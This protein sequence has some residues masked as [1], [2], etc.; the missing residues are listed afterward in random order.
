MKILQEIKTLYKN[1]SLCLFIGAGVSR[2]CGLP[3]WPTLSNAVVEAAWPN[4]YQSYDYE[5]IALRASLN[6]LSPLEAMRYARQQL[7]NNFNQ[8]V[9]NALYSNGVAIS[10]TVSAITSLQK[11]RRICCFN[12]DDII[13]EA[14]MAVSRDCTPVCEDD[15]LN[16][17]SDKCLVFHPHG[18]LS[19]KVWPRDYDASPIVLS[20]DDYHELYSVP[21]S[22]ANILQAVLLLGHSTLFIG[23]SLT[24]PNTR[25]LLDVCKRLRIN[26]KHFALLQNPRYHPEAKGW[27]PLAYTGLDKFEAEFLLERGVT[28]IWFNEFSEIPAILKEIG[29]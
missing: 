23:M 29:S 28:V 4:R 18:F 16:L 1:N 11:V 15:E 7:G 8:I 2:S 24:D 5:H 12:Y 9:K 26:Q 14:L 13:E 10:E 25:R 17:L 21:Y 27:E 19:R 6:K 22:W 20:E 3:D